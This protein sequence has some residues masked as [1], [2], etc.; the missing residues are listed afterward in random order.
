MTTP[1][2]ELYP[3]AGENAFASMMLTLIR[4]NIADHD[5]KRDDF[6]RMNG[7]V[8][9]VAEDIDAAVTLHFRRGRLSVQDGVIGIPDVAIRGE[10]AALVDM[11][12]IPPD[13]R[14]ASLPNLRSAPAK[15]LLTA[16]KSRKLR[17]HGVLSHL[18]LGARFARVMS[19]Y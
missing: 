3:G 10:A 1:M 5:S 13:P 4:Q 18:A 16:L 15:A 11:S 6:L 7:R 14:F 9:L 19:V 12:R 17:V 2:I 8:N